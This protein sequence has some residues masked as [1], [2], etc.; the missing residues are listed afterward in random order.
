MSDTETQPAAR[1]A[2]TWLP[3][4]IAGVLAVLV[5][6]VAVLLPHV[7]SVSQDARDRADANTTVALSVD[8]QEAVQAA[9][10][11]AANLLTYA[12]KSFDADWQRSL[13]GASGEL[14]KEHEQQ[15]ADAQ[16]KITKNK[17]DLTAKVQHSAFESAAEGTVL[18]LVTV[19]GFT[20]NDQGTSSA[21]IPQRLEL[22][23]VNTDGKWLA[24]DLTS[25]GI[26]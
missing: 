13:D 16:A 5:A 2:P 23:M 4:V 25:I 26:Q 24:S 12:R 20:V 17:I 8:Q 7:R 11:E 22:S 9:A 19:N 10:T 3:W 14:R 1:A 15:R 6:A 18:V 21:P